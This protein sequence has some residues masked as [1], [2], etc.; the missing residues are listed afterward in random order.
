ML[1]KYNPWTQHDPLPVFVNKILL[2]QSHIL[3]LC[4]VCG[5]FHTTTAELTHCD[6]DH[7]TECISYLALDKQ[8]LLPHALWHCG[9]ALMC[10][11][12]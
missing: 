2:E 5:C 3:L 8:D 4:I 6:R 9:C 10:Q 11:A 1:A 7:K 12:T